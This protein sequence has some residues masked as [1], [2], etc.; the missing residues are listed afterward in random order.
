M[1]GQQGLF[2]N[3]QFGFK[4]GVRCTEASFTILES[5]THMLE[6]GSQV[7]GCFLDVREACDTVW[8]YGLLFKFSEFG[9]KGRMWL[10]IRNLYTGVKL[11]SST[12][13]SSQ[14]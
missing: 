10:V 1:Q 5:I 11:R 2:S 14:N 9:I 7:L 4:E 6:R 8:I 12:L 13:K 3:M